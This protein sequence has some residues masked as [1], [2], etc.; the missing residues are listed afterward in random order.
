MSSPILITTVIGLALAA[1]SITG[2]APSMV[3]AIAA[4]KVENNVSRAEALMQQIVRY[5]A[6]EGEYPTTVAD[7]VGK[8][9][10][11][12]QN[13]TNGFGGAYTFSVD[14]TKGLVIIDTTFSDATRKTQY[15]NNYRHTFKPADIGNGVVRTI[16]VMP[17]SGSMGA[18]VINGGN[19]ITASAT[20][21][22]PAT[23]TY[24]YDTSSSA[25]VLKVSD[26]TQW[27]TAS[28]SGSTAP[29]S[30]NIV[31]SASSL[32]STGNTGDVRYV[33]DSGG[34]VL[35]TYVWYNGAWVLSGGGGAGYGADAVPDQFLFSPNSVSNVAP[36]DYATSGT[37]TVAG[38]NSSAIM[39]ATSNN[40]T[41]LQCKINGGTWGTCTGS[42][43]NGT[44]LQVRYQTPAGYNQSSS[45][46]V[47][48]GGVSATFSST[49]A[50]PSSLTASP[51]SVSFTNVFTNSSGSQ[52]IILTN[53][54]TLAATLTPTLS[55][56][57]EFSLTGNTCTSGIAANNGTCTLTVTFTPGTS[58]TAKTGTLTL[59]FNGQTIALSGTGVAPDTTPDAFSFAAATGVALSTVTTSNTVT[60]TGINKPSS[61]SVSG[62]G[63]NQQCSIAGG[64]WGTCSG[65]ISNNQTIAVRHT[66]SGS[67]NTATTTVLTVGGTSSTYTATTRVLQALTVSPTSL[68]WG[69]VALNAISSK[70]LTITNPNT[71]GVSFTTSIT[72][73]STYYSVA[74]NSC[75][76]TVPASGTC[77]VTV[78]FNPL[79]TTTA[80]SG[81]LDINY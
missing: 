21:P 32:P 20:S 66:S 11:Q 29:T 34:N 54:N 78:N 62:T 30:S 24:W 6:L 73:G 61:I 36:G 8:G 47:T 16:Y 50:S 43:V 77:T 3:E 64:A 49:T 65:T 28:S 59:G 12:N 79:A 39:S 13:N 35:N 44:T 74:S 52:T 1:V 45:A 46:T 26:G 71:W 51:S 17:T 42:A 10:W 4:R 15:L 22:N 38:V 63:T 33:Y 5:R 68:A 76:N 41:N 53:P 58:T 40:A 56:A 25:A 7:L 55:G 57:T 14:A 67:Y 37:I 72:S 27:I 70:T 60:I 31:A 48:I 9:Y 75:S 69:S 81:Q 80:Q 18:P 2:V 23:T 19:G